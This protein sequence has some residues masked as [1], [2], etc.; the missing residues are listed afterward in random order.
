[1][2]AQAR[3][4]ALVAPFKSALMGALGAALAEGPVNAVEVCRVT[5][6]A[7]ASASGSAGVR[8]GRASDRLRNPA[9]AAPAWVAPLLAAYL[10]GSR[11][12]EPHAV[13][14]EAGRHGYVEP[15]GIKPMCLTC[16]GEAIPPE[17]AARIDALYPEDRARGYAVG[18]LRGVFWVEFDD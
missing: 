3:G 10:D 17:V 7:L 18:D 5:A 11:P 4:K 8:L 9:N 16:H 6:P 13:A 1:M 15:I 12:R 14:L 2:A